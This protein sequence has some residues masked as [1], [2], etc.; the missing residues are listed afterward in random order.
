MDVAALPFAATLPGHLPGT[1]STPVQVAAIPQADGL[2]KRWH[3]DIEAFR[4]A[5]P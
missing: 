3:D 4:K 1:I 2:S 5:R